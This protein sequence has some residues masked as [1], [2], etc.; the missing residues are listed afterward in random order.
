MP[1]RTRLQPGGSDPLAE[2]VERAKLGDGDALGQIVQRTQQWVYNLGYRILRNRQEAEDLAQEVYVRVWR[3]LPGFRGDSKFTTWLHSI[4]TH[5][6]LNRLRSLRRESVAWADSDEMLEHLLDSQQGSESEPYVES[7]DKEFIW[8]QVD[9]LPRKYA[10]VLTLFYQHEL[11]YQEITEVLG[12]PLGTVKAQ[13]NRA[14]L[15]LADCLREANA[16]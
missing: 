15:A 5:A 3:A 11:S 14:R 7:Q 4:A 16:E 8:Q 10:L 9:R 12:L 6:S 13:L 2:L 1:L